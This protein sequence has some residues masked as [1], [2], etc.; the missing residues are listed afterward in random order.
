MYKKCSGFSNKNILLFIIS[1][2]I[3]YRIS[4]MQSFLSLPLFL[5]LYLVKNGNI[6]KSRDKAVFSFVPS[7]CFEISFPYLISYE[8]ASAHG[9]YRC[10][11]IRLVTRHPGRGSES[12]GGRL[13]VTFMDSL[14]S[15]RDPAMRIDL[16]KDEGNKLRRAYRETAGE[17]WKDTSCWPWD[18]WTATEKIE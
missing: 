9:R 14:S 1:V 15:E 5:F 17:G 4:R 8:H 3:I 6:V 11:S 16:R 2:R 12:E 10:V 18:R 7:S 13:L